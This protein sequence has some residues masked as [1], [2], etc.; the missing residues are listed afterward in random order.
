MND[1]DAKMNEVFERMLPSVKRMQELQRRIDL[2][3]LRGLCDP[4]TV[5]RVRRD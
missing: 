3:L 1:L 2:E 4:N 5:W